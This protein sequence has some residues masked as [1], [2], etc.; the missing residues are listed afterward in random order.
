MINKLE[1][2]YIKDNNKWFCKSCSCELY[3]GKKKYSSFCSCLSKTEQSSIYENYLSDFYKIHNNIYE[4][5]KCGQNITSGREKHYF[6]CL[7]IGTRR[8]QEKSTLNPTLFS[9]YCDMGCGQESKF[10]YNSCKAYCCKLGAKCPTKV[11]KDRQ[12]KLGKN[13]FEGKTHPRGM[14]GKIPYNKGLTKETSEIVA[15]TGLAIKQAFLLH[16]DKRKK[17]HHTQEAKDKISDNMKQRYASGWETIC[18]RAKKY[19]HISPIAGE[20]SVDGTWELAFA[21]MLD[22]VNIQWNRNKKRFPYINLD[23]EDS[24]YQPDFFVSAWN[25]YIEVKGYQTDL[26]DCKWTQFN[27]PLLI[28]K[29]EHIKVIKKWLNNHKDIDSRNFFDLIKESTKE[30]NL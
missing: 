27:E 11:E 25:T 24:T 19:K 21:K 30:K 1:D 23:S 26:D 17:K 29:R 7:G 5:S 3:T 16:G 22:K 20:I 2:R 28:V 10:F 13:P 9:K 18:G 6:S 8:S 15:R 12:K 4:C 14:L